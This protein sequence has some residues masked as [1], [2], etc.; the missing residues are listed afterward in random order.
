MA[1]ECPEPR[2]G[3]LKEIEEDLEELYNGQDEDSGN[4]EA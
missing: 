3:D 1:K 4:E 2:R